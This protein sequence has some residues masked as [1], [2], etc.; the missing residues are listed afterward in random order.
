MNREDRVDQAISYNPWYLVSP[1]QICLIVFQLTMFLPSGA[2]RNGV[3]A[4]QRR[5]DG[6]SFQRSS[7]SP[8]LPAS[9]LP[10]NRSPHRGRSVM[11]L[12][13]DIRWDDTALIIADDRH[14]AIGRGD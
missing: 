9:M 13:I 6:T 8:I 5:R 14:T 3:R 7:R 2:Q 11:G 12:T 4:G 1:L 10:C